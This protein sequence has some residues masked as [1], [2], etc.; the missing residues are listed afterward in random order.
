MFHK[1]NICSKNSFIILK[2]LGRNE[3]KSFYVREIAGKVDLSPGTVSRTL[4]GLKESAIVSREDRGRL[5]MYMADNK[6]PLLREIKIVITLTEINELLIDLKPLTSKII[7]FGS[8]ARGED[9]Y[10]SDI[11]MLILSEDRKSVLRKTSNFLS[12]RKLSAI[13]ITKDEYFRLRTQDK[14]FYN[15]IKSGKLLWESEREYDD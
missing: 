14:P 7:L 4:S 13:V 12:E 9:R 3:G 11:D 15:Q 2:F 1:L 8:C 10:D 6:N 5:A